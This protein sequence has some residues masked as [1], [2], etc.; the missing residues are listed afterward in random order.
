VADG[1]ASADRKDGR[2]AAALEGQAR[3]ADCIDPSMKA[4]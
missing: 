2:N 4:V 1:G 3:M